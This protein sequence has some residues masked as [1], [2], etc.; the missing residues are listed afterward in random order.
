[1]RALWLPL[2]LWGCLGHRTIPGNPA[3]LYHRGDPSGRHHPNPQDRRPW[4]GNPAHDPRLGER[5]VP[6]HPL[7]QCIGGVLQGVY[8]LSWTPPPST[9]ASLRQKWFPHVIRASHRVWAGYPP[10]DREQGGLEPGASDP[11][12]PKPLVPLLLNYTW[13]SASAS[14][15]GSQRSNG[16]AAL[17]EPAL[18]SIKHPHLLP[19]SSPPGLC[20]RAGIRPPS[21]GC[22]GLHL[23]GVL[24]QE[25]G[26]AGCHEASA[27]CRTLVGAT[28]GVQAGGHQEGIPRRGLLL[29]WNLPTWYVHSFVGLSVCLSVCPPWLA[30]QDF[31]VLAS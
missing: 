29:L 3:W 30:C 10:S 1:M 18:L 7:P 8:G 31:G 15:G 22:V 20:P 25:W 23:S 16:P 2:L 5:S 27:G 11:E 14:A 9:G 24:F 26:R 28:A 4:D 13:C 19:S 12:P 6:P 21:P 17:S